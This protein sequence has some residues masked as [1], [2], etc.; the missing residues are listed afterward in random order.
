[1]VFREAL[2]LHEKFR[3]KIFLYRWGR[4]LCLWI[5]GGLFFLGGCSVGSGDGVEREFLK[6]GHSQNLVKSMQALGQVNDFREVFIFSKDASE[7]MLIVEVVETE[8]T[9]QNGLMFRKKLAEDHGMLFVFQQASKLSFWMK[10]TLIPLDMI[11]VDEK[12]KIVH[13][14]HAAQPCEADPCRVYSS[15]VA[16]K[17]VLEINGGLSRKLG[18]QTGDRVGW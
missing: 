13:I 17:Y 2:V 10:N 14:E 7:I 15:P 12:G 11:F 9:R 1:M 3:M 6:N 8:E 18:I 4:V 16:A 5:F